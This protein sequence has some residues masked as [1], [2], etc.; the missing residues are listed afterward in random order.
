MILVFLGTGVC[1][2]NFREFKINYVYIF[3]IVAMNKMN[4][5]QMYKIFLLLLT[6]WMVTAL[7]EVLEIKHYMAVDFQSN[8]YKTW[9]TLIFVGLLGGLLVNPLDIME[10]AFRYELLY[11]LF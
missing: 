9:P 10:R 11:C 5:Y 7:I 2:A 4:Q 8:H 1:I 3:G 6:L